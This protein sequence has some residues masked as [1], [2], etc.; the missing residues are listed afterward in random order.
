MPFTRGFNNPLR[1]RETNY[2]GPGQCPGVFLL[3]RAEVLNVRY[4]PKADMS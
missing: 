4:W 1:F 3:V 2:R